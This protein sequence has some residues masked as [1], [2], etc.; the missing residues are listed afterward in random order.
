MSILG[1]YLVTNVSFGQDGIRVEYMEQRFQ[2][3]SGGIE[4]ALVMT[5]LDDVKV[6]VI[7]EIQE[8]LSEFITEFM[9]NLPD[10]NSPD[11]LPTNRFQRIR[12][13]RNEPVEA[14]DEA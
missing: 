8:V 11:T 9:E 1:D 6:A 4:S 7:M 13:V 3:E 14:P 5:D 10:R 2:T 12:E